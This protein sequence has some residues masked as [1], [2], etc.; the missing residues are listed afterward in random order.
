MY[1]SK[2]A[3]KGAPQNAPGGMTH[4]GL[5]DTHFVIPNLVIPARGLTPLGGSIMYFSKS[6]AKGA[7]QKN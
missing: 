1:F 6:A 5:L 7:P 2:W 3:A 4:D